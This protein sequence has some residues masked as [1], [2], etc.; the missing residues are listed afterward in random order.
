MIDY[1]ELSRSRAWRF[2]LAWVCA[3]LRGRPAARPSRATKIIKL[4]SRPSVTPSGLSMSG[5][6]ATCFHLGCTTIERSKDHFPIDVP[7][8]AI[9]EVLRSLGRDAAAAVGF[10]YF[11]PDVSLHSHSSPG[12]RVS[13]HQEISCQKWRAYCCICLGIGHACSSKSSCLRSMLAGSTLARR[14]HRDRWRRFERTVGVTR[15]PFDRARTRA[16]SAHGD[17][18]VRSI[19]AL[20]QNQSPTT[21]GGHPL[22]V[23]LRPSSFGSG[24]PRAD[25]RGRDSIHPAADIRCE[26]GLVDHKKTARH[27]RTVLRHTHAAKRQEITV[28]V[29]QS[30]QV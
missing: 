14:R 2:Y 29:N 24:R 5:D 20:D 19:A 26:F 9:P 30:T 28:Q 12:A 18:A 13:L 16:D 4:P 3:A 15:P 6:S 23:E 7:R 10:N 27:S 1:P 25:L 8:A 21:Y 22:W 17:I 11:V